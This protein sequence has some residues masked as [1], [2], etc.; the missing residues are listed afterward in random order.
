M[1][2]FLLPLSLLS[3]MPGAAFAG[4]VTLDFDVNPDDP[5]G[6]ADEIAQDGLSY[7]AA[8]STVYTGYEDT[9]TIG[10]APGLSDTDVVSARPGFIFDALTI[11]VKRAD[12]ETQVMDCDIIPKV[13]TP[14]GEVADCEDVG[15]FEFTPTSTITNPPPLEIETTSQ[16]GSVTSQIITLDESQIDLSALPGMTDL[17]AIRFTLGIP[18]PGSNFSP[19]FDDETNSW[20]TCEFDF[21]CGLISLDNLVLDVRGSSGPFAAAPIPLPLS[22]GL[23][24]GGLALLGATA[25]RK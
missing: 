21:Q 24:L 6:Y 20:Y 12:I 16:D 19:L 23:L 4:S 5:S 9:L 14:W 17:T 1:K 25:R 15:G 8:N 3:I 7:G 10:G 13:T 22:A 11:D 2:K 18:R